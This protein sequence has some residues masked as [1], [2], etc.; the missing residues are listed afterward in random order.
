MV[1]KTASGGCFNVGIIQTG[2]TGNLKNNNQPVVTATETVTA[3]AKEKLY[4]NNSLVVMATKSKSGGRYHRT[5]SNWRE[6]I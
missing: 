6:K 1:N 5:F 3:I 2:K 4:I